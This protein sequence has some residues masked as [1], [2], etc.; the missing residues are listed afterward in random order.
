MRNHPQRPLARDDESN[1]H[2]PFPNV[3]RLTTANFSVN[4][5]T[6]SVLLARRFLSGQ[7]GIQPQPLTAWLLV[8]QNFGATY[9]FVKHLFVSCI[10]TT[11]L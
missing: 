11:E 6:S 4:M 3:T 5:D 10:Q 7:R 8:C 2:A 1:H 9:Q